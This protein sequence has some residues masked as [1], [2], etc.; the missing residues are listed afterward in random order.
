VFAFLGRN[1]PWLT[2]R[3]LKKALYDPMRVTGS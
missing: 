1:E 2:E 3:A